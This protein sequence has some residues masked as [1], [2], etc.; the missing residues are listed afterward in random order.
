MY[1]DQFVVQH[2]QDWQVQA[3]MQ[4][5][6]TMFAT[7]RKRKIIEFNI[8]T[9]YLARM[10]IFFIPEYTTVWPECCCL[11]RSAKLICGVNADSISDSNHES[12]TV[13]PQIEFVRHLEGLLLDC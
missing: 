11:R 1:T 6:I 2:R 10:P 3:S 13:L 9:Q 5:M 4:L 8:A 7:E 12:I